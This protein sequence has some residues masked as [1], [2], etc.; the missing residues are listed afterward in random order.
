M[1]VCV[2][3]GWKWWEILSGIVLHA[4]CRIHNLQQRAFQARVGLCFCWCLPV[5]VGSGVNEMRRVHT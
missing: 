4:L 5:L 3:E 1:D 2:W